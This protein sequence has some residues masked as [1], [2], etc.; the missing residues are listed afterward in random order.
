MNRK[1]RRTLESIF[2]QPTPKT[3]PWN[4]I[5]SLFRACGAE[6]TEGA[7][8]RLRI[9][10]GDLTATFHRP[11]PANVAT[12]GMIKRVRKFLQSAGIVP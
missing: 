5:E 1:Q 8:S 12:V 6:T 4:D 9:Q 11:H 10:F 3:M 2:S 7:G